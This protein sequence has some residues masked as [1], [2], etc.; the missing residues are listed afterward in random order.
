MC[1]NTQYLIDILSEYSDLKIELSECINFLN[2]F[3]KAKIKSDNMVIGITGSGGSGIKKPNIGTIAALYLS[4]IP[5]IKV[6][7]TGSSKKTGIIGSTDLLNY[8]GYTKIKKKDVFYD[9]YGFCYY[10]V[11]DISKWKK[12]ENILKI[13]VSLCKILNIIAYNEFQYDIKFTGTVYRKYAEQFM[14]KYMVNEPKLWYIYGG[15]INDYIIDEFIPGH[16]FIISKNIHRSFFIKESQ[17]SKNDGN[18]SELNNSL[19]MS[20]CDDCF[21]YESLK[22]TVAIYT[23]LCGISQNLNEGIEIFEKIYKTKMVKILLEEMK[24]YS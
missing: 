7:K 13:N 16:N 15:F 21:W 23:Y 12:Y 5:N 4:C 18:I 1:D 6:I 14:G 22:Y 3:N 20:Q 11:N 10:D 24:N 17:K 2:R 9:R 19:I 8:I